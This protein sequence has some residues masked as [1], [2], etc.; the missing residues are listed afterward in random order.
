M[1]AAFQAVLE[2]Y[3]FKLNERTERAASAIASP[4]NSEQVKMNEIKVL[5]LIVNTAE[6][7][8]ETI[9]PLANPLDARWTHLFAR[10][11]TGPPPKTRFSRA[12][13]KH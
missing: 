8:A 7:C 11:S 4:R 5:V 6:Y 9:S 12:L 1:F 3:A 10:E 13:Q 2:T